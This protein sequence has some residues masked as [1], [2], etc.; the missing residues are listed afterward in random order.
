[1]IVIVLGGL[2]SLPKRGNHLSVRDYALGH[3]GMR[4]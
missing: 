1:V 3:E 4:D 2:L